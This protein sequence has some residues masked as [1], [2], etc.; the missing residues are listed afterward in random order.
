MRRRVRYLG[1]L[2]AAWLIAACTAQPGSGPRGTPRP[3]ARHIAGQPL[4]VCTIKGDHPV[5]AQA[6]A[7]CGT[8][9]VPE[10]RSHPGGRQIGLRVAV[11]PAVATEHEPDPLFVVAG[12]PGE[13]ATQFFAWL[14]AVFG[15]VHARRDIVL[16][17]QRGTGASNAVRLPEMPTTAGLPKTKADALLSAWAGEGALRDHL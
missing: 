3:S 14:P 7:L 12:G 2:A 17:D 13:A 1:V 10:D 11:V 4:T 6:A 5:Q 15:D 9:Q 16:I 8:L